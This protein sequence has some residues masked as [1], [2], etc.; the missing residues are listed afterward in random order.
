LFACLDKIED[1]KDIL[2]KLKF[3][4][5]NPPPEIVSNFASKEER[6]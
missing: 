1:I 5:L 6:I 3:P 4:T 2:R